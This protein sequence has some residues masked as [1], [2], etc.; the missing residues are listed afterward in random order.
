MAFLEQALNGDAEMKARFWASLQ[1]VLSCQDCGPYAKIIED[2]KAGENICSG[3]GLVVGSPMIDEGTEWRTFADDDKSSGGD[4]S[5]IGRTA[6]RNLAIIRGAMVL[7]STVV[8]GK[9]VGAHLAKTQL[10]LDEDPASTA[11]A[12]ARKHLSN[13]QDR[14]SIP[15][16]TV[17]AAEHIF[18]KALAA[19]GAAEQW[20]KAPQR[21][22]LLATAL[23]A[24]A[25]LHR[26]HLAPV[27]A[28]RIFR[29]SLNDLTAQLPGM[30]SF[31]PGS[32]A[33]MGLHVDS[34]EMQRLALDFK[35]EDWRAQLIANLRLKKVPENFI[36]VCASLVPQAVQVVD[37]GM[38]QPRPR[39][40]MAAI[41]C[42]AID[43]GNSFQLT[44]GFE[45]PTRDEICA[46]FECADGSMVRYLQAFK[47]HLNKFEE[48][49]NEAQRPRVKGRSELA[50]EKA[51][52]HQR[53]IEERKQAAKFAAS[54]FIKVECE[55][56]AAAST[57]GVM[58][59][60]MA[61]VGRIAEAAESRKRRGASLKNGKA[62]KRN[63]P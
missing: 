44:G 30:V 58:D 5:R 18:A 61:E 16:R 8:V 31:L 27:E 11:L 7:E 60:D 42:M 51:M 2:T 10:K 3:C 45:W 13:L 32:D 37:L 12:E 57:S 15:N 35:G 20:P 52:Q 53:E 39:T 48:V 1:N 54:S 14:L 23:V 55:E 56:P 46:W 41:A 40:A 21:T 49:V 9:G 34:A 36:S 22:L 50:M 62:A 38:H 6:D 28:S 29:V 59:I 47:R 43:L 33:N 25:K 24:G 4:P 17:A 26:F 19:A 63:K